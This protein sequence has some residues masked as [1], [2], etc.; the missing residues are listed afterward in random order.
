MKKTLLLKGLDC[1]NCSA[2]IEK[3]VGELGGVNASCVNLMKQ[4]LTIDVD[5][6]KA[7][8]IVTQIETI[9]HAHEPD[10]VVSEKTTPQ[11]TKVYLLKGLDC[12]NCSAK[13]EKEVGELNGVSAST[14]N[15][16]KQTLTVCVNA[17]EAVSVA[18]QIETIVHAH[19]PDVSVS[20]YIDE[21]V[22]KPILNELEKYGEYRV[23][24][25]PDHP[26][27]LITMT[28]ARDPVP[29]LIY[30]NKVAQ[31]GVETFTEATAKTTGVYFD[32]G[33]DVMKRLLNKN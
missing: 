9:V 1:P 7:G 18:T 25:M 29:F 17:M 15:L 24:I 28:H 14:V 19:E 10:V 21:R 3:E 27:P 4:T 2:K 8:T 5:T 11:I 6:E 26:T 31:R 32:H 13:I 22:L 20:E 33:P 30:D 12:P 23:L 16:M